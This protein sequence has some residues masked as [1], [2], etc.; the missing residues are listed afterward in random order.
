MFSS[1]WWGCGRK[2]F[3]SCLFLRYTKSQNRSSWHDSN[4]MTWSYVLLKFFAG[5]DQFQPAYAAL[6]L[7]CGG[8]MSTFTSMLGTECAK[9]ISLLTTG[10]LYPLLNDSRIYKSCFPI[11]R[12]TFFFSLTSFCLEKS[13]LEFTLHPFF[14]WFDWLVLSFVYFFFWISYFNEYYIF[15]RNT[16]SKMIVILLVSVI[17]LT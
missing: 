16:S 14:V 1:A 3:S 13:I 15:I 5:S 9:S 11:I 8:A 10:I 4:H 12:L 2:T 7:E 17:A 6:C